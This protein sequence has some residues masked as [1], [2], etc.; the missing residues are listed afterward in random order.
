MPHHFTKATTE[1][2]IWC[3]KEGKMTM[4][5]VADGRRQYCLSCQAKKDQAR[6]AEKAAPPPVEQRRLF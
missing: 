3:N 5:R 6:L 1:A 4:W 2:S